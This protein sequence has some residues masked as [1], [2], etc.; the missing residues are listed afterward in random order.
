VA[1]RLF[2]RTE[3]AVVGRMISAIAVN[4]VY[5]ILPVKIARRGRS[6]DDTK[7]R[8]SYP[9]PCHAGGRGF[10]KV[11]RD[12]SFRYPR[13]C[14][15]LLLLL[16]LPSLELRYTSAARRFAPHAKPRTRFAAAKTAGV[17]PL[18][19]AAMLRGAGDCS[20]VPAT[21]G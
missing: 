13:M 14:I 19:R 17:P 5:S 16:T 11:Q 12:A 18:T 9:P 6:T 3:A 8:K 4:G 21:G 7:A 1:E 10:Q 2:V 20:F 15:L